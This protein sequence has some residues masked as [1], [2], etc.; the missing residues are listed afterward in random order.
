MSVL[1][2]ERRGRLDLFVTSYDEYL[3][4]TRLLFYSPF[5]KN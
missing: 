4:S 2:P 1:G 3:S 5:G